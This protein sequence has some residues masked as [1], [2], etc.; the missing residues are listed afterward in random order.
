MNLVLRQD[1]IA[2]LSIVTLDANNQYLEALSLASNNS[3]IYIS[4][5]NNPIG[6]T[7]SIPFPSSGH[8]SGIFVTGSDD[9]LFLSSG[10]QLNL[11]FNSIDASN[12]NQY[13]LWQTLFDNPTGKVLSVFN[14]DKSTIARKQSWKFRIN[15]VSGNSSGT[16]S[17]W[18]LDTSVLSGVNSAT[19]SSSSKYLIS[20]QDTSIG[21]TGPQG[22]VG[23]TGPAGVTGPPGSGGGITG[24]TGETGPVG[25]TGETGPTGAAGETGPVGPTGETGPAGPTGETGPVGPT[26]ETGPAGPTGFT[27]ETGPQGVGGSDGPNS[28]RLS[29]GASASSNPGAT[30]SFNIEGGLSFSS[31][32]ALIFNAPEP[33]NSY[34]I[35]GSSIENWLTNILSDRTANKTTNAQISEVGNPSNYGIYIAYP[36]TPTP[37]FLWTLTFVSGNG[38]FSADRIYTISAISSGVQG[39]TGP[40]GSVIS[41][42]SVPTYSG[43][44]GQYGEM[45]LGLSGSTPYLYVYTDQWYQFM[46]ATF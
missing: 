38:T 39:P 5:D 13:D 45:R 23:P 4:N 12:F 2:P 32:T 35:Y 1:T 42:Q 17:S 28:I 26:G 44:T 18:I 27:G 7:E 43:D 20:W 10:N 6:F 11:Q 15:S 25:P 29:F 19:F 3:M 21:S 31:A 8:F 46:G 34:D 37:N 16:Y 22:D 9:G 24:P 14:I 41:T 33:N 36:V 40:T 30:G